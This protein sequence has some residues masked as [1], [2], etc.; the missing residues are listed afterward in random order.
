MSGEEGTPRAGDIVEREMPDALKD[1][2]GDE[3]TSSWKSDDEELMLVFYWRLYIRDDA[4]V[5][6]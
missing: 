2:I 1:G 5:L 4:G 6:G 3:A